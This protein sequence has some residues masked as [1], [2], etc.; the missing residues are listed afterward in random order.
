MASFTITGIVS[1]SDPVVLCDDSG[2]S[3]CSDFNF[4]HL[5]YDSSNPKSLYNNVNLYYTHLEKYE[6]YSKD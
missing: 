3:S 5:S 1:G 6:E 2:S 4:L